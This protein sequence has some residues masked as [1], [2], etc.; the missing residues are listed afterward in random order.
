MLP[1]A[2]NK[3][4]VPP[5]SPVCTPVCHQY[6]T[7]GWSSHLPLTQWCSGTGWGRNIMF[8]RNQAELPPSSENSCFL[9]LPLHIFQASLLGIGNHVSLALSFSFLQYTVKTLTIWI[10][11]QAL[12]SSKR[13]PQFP[14]SLYFL[15]Q[16]LTLPSTFFI[17]NPMDTL[18]FKCYRSKHSVLKYPYSSFFLNIFLFFFIWNKLFI[19]LNRLCSV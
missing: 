8:V 13:K 9:L 1:T 2:V 7:R 3:T 10:S 15:F 12:Q 17:P 14:E 16:D 4:P 18:V 11:F 6:R 19:W 5:T